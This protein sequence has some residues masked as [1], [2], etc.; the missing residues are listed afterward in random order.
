MVKNLNTS[1][2]YIYY[3]FDNLTS[4]PFKLILHPGDIKQNGSCFT[5]EEIIFLRDADHRMQLGDRYW[6]ECKDSRFEKKK[7]KY[8]DP[9]EDDSIEPIENIPNLIEDDP[10]DLL[11]AE[12]K[13]EIENDRDAK[14]EKLR[15]FLK[16]ISPNELEMY[17]ELYENGLSNRAYAQ[18]IGKSEGTVRYRLNNFKKKIKD[19]CE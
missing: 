16:E 15:K 9:N 8:L 19:F 5:E 3:G 14:L 18:K 1:I 13:P 4:K 2:E 11:T 17:H 10:V 7:I 12:S 6:E